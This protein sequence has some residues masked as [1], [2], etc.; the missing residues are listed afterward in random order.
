MTVI[1]TIYLGS[2][3]AANWSASDV[4]AVLEHTK[5]W[6]KF[7]TIIEAHGIY[8]GELVPTLLIKVG[9]TDVVKVIDLAGNLGKLFEQETV[10]LEHDS[11]L[12]IV[13]VSDTVT[14]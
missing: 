7:A 4:V 11:Q 2:K 10:G 9:A 13:R 8:K 3:G 1:Y 6:F 14:L 5:K 12:K